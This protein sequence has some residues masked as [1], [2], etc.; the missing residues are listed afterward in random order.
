MPSYP[1]P[2]SDELTHRERL[3]A[4]GSR[5]LAGIIA[6]DRAAL[7]R[8]LAT[9]VVVDGAGLERTQLY[10]SFPAELEGEQS[11]ERFVRDAIRYALDER[12]LFEAGVVESTGDELGLTVPA[13][14]DAYEAAYDL[15]RSEFAAGIGAGSEA[16]TEWGFRAAM[17]IWGLAGDDPDVIKSLRSVYSS[18]TTQNAAFYDRVLESWG[19]A[20]VE[21]FTTEKLAVAL[22]SMLDG[23]IIRAR[24]DSDAVSL[25]GETFADAATALV[26][27]VIRPKDGPG[28]SAL[29]RFNVI[30]TKHDVEASHGASRSGP[31]LS[32][33]TR[34]AAFALFDEAIG[35]SVDPRSVT[36]AAIASRAGC[37]TTTVTRLWGGVSLLLIDYFYSAIDEAPFPDGSTLGDNLDL[38]A[39][40]AD[41]LDVDGDDGSSAQLLLII[42]RMLLE[43]AQFGHTQRLLCGAALAAI[44]FGAP[45]A[46]GKSLRDA[47]DDRLGRR[48]ISSRFEHVI[49]LG[50]RIGVLRDET[51][52]EAV[53]LGNLLPVTV[54]HQAVRRDGWTPRQ[55][56][57]TVYSTLLRGLVLKPDE[58]PNARAATRFP[59]P[60]RESGKGSD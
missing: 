10:R 14:L 44:E 47:R 27:A 3:L 55:V 7:A 18:G 54:L 17:A 20:L 16:G 11:H 6:G 31:R 23:M 26:A 9:Q 51:D 5:V 42:G 21:P 30:R 50:Q 41:R 43:V 22:T 29:D 35:A 4:A 59:L 52:L 28:T 2:T 56:A 13:P 1:D 53:E 24:F 60:Q 45:D 38:L 32:E 37:S 33:V 34:T 36:P 40:A 48:S 58:L 49:D 19:C 25:D 12:F 46:S 15:A 57:E 39:E 8:V